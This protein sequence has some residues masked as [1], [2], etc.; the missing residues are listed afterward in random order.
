MPASFTQ[1]TKTIMASFFVGA[2]LNQPALAAAQ[3]F[4]PI[5]SHNAGLRQEEEERTKRDEEAAKHVSVENV[6]RRRR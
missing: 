4:D 6:K 1:N 2:E 3:L 5:A